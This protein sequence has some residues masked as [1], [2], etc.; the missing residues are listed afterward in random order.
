[1]IEENNQ[2]VKTNE[3][4]K[5]SVKRVIQTVMNN[6]QGHTDKQ[7]STR[8]AFVQTFSQVSECMHKVVIKTL[9][10]ILAVQSL[11][12]WSKKSPCKYIKPIEP[13]GST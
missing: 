7:L 8:I 3:I 4:K 6:L 10:I 13:S 9:N 11:Q 1:M 5:N 2:Q 12:F